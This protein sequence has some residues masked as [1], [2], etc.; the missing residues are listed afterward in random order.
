MMT[1]NVIVS[2]SLATAV[3]ITV[4]IFCEAYYHTNTE[5]MIE[6]STRNQLFSNIL[7]LG[8]G[9][10]LP[11][12]TE[13]ICKSLSSGNIAI[14][15]VAKWFIL[16]T[17]SFPNYMMF[18]VLFPL[19]N[20][21]F[22][23]CIKSIQFILIGGISLAIIHR[24]GYSIWNKAQIYSLYSLY[25]TCIM[26]HF[27]QLCI[28]S[29]IILQII[30]YILMV[31]IF[32][33]FSHLSYLWYKNIKLTSFIYLSIQ[34]FYCTCYI[35]FLWLFCI[36]QILLFLYFKHILWYETDT[37]YLIMNTLFFVIYLNFITILS[38]IVE[39]KKT[40]NIMVTII[41]LLYYYI[42]F[43]YINMLYIAR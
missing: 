34:E 5:N 16:V 22:M 20:Y 41:F 31:C 13:L 9:S 25:I 28:K 3:S 14:E 27:I 6:L 32:I 23:P 38:H 35:S 12:F 1:R 4:L 2:I 8:I 19:S 42:I 24:N 33:Q 43:L 21:N 7:M 26:L 15:L 36:S 10:S 17:L 18:F 30:L 29:N 39:F 40:I 11:V 37:N